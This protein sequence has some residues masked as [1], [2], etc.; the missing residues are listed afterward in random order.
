[1]SALTDRI[2]DDWRV[3]NAGGLDALERAQWV[4]DAIQAARRWRS[5]RQRPGLAGNSVSAALGIAGR[6][7]PGELEASHEGL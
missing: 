2:Y 6:A 7:L 5:A 1:M 3:R 4:A